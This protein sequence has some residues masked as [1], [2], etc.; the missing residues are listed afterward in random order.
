M[1]HRW[2]SRRAPDSCW[3]WTTHGFFQVSEAMPAAGRF[4]ESSA[5]FGGKDQGESSDGNEELGIL[6]FDPAARSKESPPAVTS[7]CT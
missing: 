3:Q 4:L 1:A 6:R 7:M 2:E 5:H